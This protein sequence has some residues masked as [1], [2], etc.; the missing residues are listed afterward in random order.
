MKKIII[1]LCLAVG[2]GTVFTGCSDFLDSDYLFD[3]KISIEKVF[4]DKNYTNEWLAYAYEFLNNNEMQQAC[5]KKTIAFNFADD[6]Y[7]GDYDYSGWRCGTYTETGNKINLNI[8][9]NAY[10]AI[11][12]V[13]IFLNNV[14]MNKELSEADII[15]MKGQAHFLRAYFYWVLVRTFGPVPIVPDE[16][17]DYTKEYVEISLLRNS[18]D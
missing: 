7:Y 9:E 18:Y 14:D 13:S 3:K 16:T 4:A 2:L 17:I 1:H 15:D 10:K 12:Q 6:M 8:W 5:S 11:R